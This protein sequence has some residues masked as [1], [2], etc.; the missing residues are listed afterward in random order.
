VITKTQSFTRT[1]GT[2]PALTPRSN[3]DI[4]KGAVTVSKSSIRPHTDGQGEAE[5]DGNAHLSNITNVLVNRFRSDCRF[6]TQF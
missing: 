5:V 4:N 1:T 6:Q 3:R 2:E